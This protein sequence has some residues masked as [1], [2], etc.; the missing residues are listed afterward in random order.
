MGFAALN[1]S[2]DSANSVLHVLHQPLGTDLG[3]V[4]VA[5]GIGRHAL[6]GAGGGRLLDR[7]GNEACHH[8]VADAA[9][10]DA[11]LPAVV[12][13]RHRFGFGIGHVDDVV[14]VDED[15]ARPAELIPHIEQ[16]AVLVPDLDA[17]VLPVALEQAAAR[18]HRQRV[19]GIDVAGGRALLAPGL[20]EFAVAVELDDARIG[21]AAM[22]VAHEDV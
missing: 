10:P 16:G 8:A 20:D 4:D 2:Y 17:V 19:R 3:A 12:I 5:C 13:L 15:A 7:V 14:L 22:P 18:I 6:R 11:A 9:D 1:P 21:V